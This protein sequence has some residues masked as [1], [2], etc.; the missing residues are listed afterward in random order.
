LIAVPANLSAYAAGLS[1]WQH[2]VISRLANADTDRYDVAL[3]VDTRTRIQVIVEREWST[4]R[5]TRS[6]Q[7]L[8]RWLDEQ[9]GPNVLR[10]A[11]LAEQALREATSTEAPTPYPTPRSARTSPVDSG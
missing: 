3:L 8:A 10:S 11:T 2:R 6:R 4:T 5:R 9:G 1:L 7:V